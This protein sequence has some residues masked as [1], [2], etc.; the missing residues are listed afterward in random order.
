M[1]KDKPVPRILQLKPDHVEQMGG[2]V[3]AKAKAKAKQKA[4]AK[5]GG[6]TGLL[7]SLAVEIVCY[8]LCS[9]FRFPFFFFFFC[10]RSTSPP[11][12]FLWAKMKNGP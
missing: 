1:G 7:P 2:K 6:R 12:D 8:D 10:F 11:L 5:N 9:Y 4:K 3:L